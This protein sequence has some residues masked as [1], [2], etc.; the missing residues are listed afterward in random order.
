MVMDV[1]LVNLMFIKD[2]LV[3]AAIMTFTSLEKAEKHKPLLKF[4]PYSIGMLLLLF[5]VIGS[6][7]PHGLC[8][9]IGHKKTV[10]DASHLLARIL[11]TR[12]RNNLLIIDIVGEL[13][14][15]RY[16]I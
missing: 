7:P 11:S 10:L 2:L 4:T 5:G 9:F 14:P 3:I 13:K 6:D 1:S 12:S 16:L 15:I 8:V